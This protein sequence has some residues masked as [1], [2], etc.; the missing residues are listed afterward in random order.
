[1]IKLALVLSIVIAMMSFGHFV[2]AENQKLVCVYQPM[3][4]FMDKSLPDLISAQVQTHGINVKTV[5][6]IDQILGHDSDCNV[7]IKIDR[8]INENYRYTDKTVKYQVVNNTITIF[9]YKTSAVFSPSSGG[10]SL[11][12]SYGK[13]S[14]GHTF[15]PMTNWSCETTAHSTKY[16][17]NYHISQSGYIATSTGYCDPFKGSVD[18]SKVGELPYNVIRSSVDSSLLALRL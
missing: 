10:G 18:P 8:A 17:N 14:G 7:I 1:M 6:I 11:G 5:R 12:A 13:G 4:L 2:Y 9:T 15:V 16:Y 3:D